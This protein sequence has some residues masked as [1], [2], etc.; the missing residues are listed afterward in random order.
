MT[1]VRDPSPRRYAN[2]FVRTEGGNGPDGMAVDAAGRLFWANFSGGTIGVADAVG[3]PVGEIR[4]PPE[5][6]L[7]VTNVTFHEGFLYITEAD[8][9]DIW[10][11][12]I[13]TAGA[14][15]YYDG[16]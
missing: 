15:L 1:A 16:K 12:P 14:P 3:H 5:A 10:R 11:M 4:L 8:K 9:G 2:V 13:K 7:K 6:G